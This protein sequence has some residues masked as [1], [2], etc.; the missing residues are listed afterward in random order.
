MVSVL[1][2]KLVFSRDQVVTSTSASKNFGQIKEAARSA[3]VFVSDRNSGIDTVI[4]SF[5]E[6]ERMA[7]E[8]DGLREERLYARAAARL[9]EAGSDYSEEGPSLEEVMGAE[10]Y[11]AFLAQDPDAIPDSELFE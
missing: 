8:L 10:G 5:D 7:V 6:F 3:P 11:R 1:N 4:V 9:A 2:H